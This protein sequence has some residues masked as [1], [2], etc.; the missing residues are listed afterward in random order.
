ML[1]S[2]NNIITFISNSEILTLLRYKVLI[3]LI[4]GML[5]S[6]LNLSRGLQI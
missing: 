2:S 5:D 4:A 6:F 3:Y 1:D